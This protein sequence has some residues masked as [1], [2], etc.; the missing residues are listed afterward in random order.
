MN[1]RISLS[2]HLKD[3]KWRYITG[4]LLLMAT[5]GIQAVIPRIS[6]NIIDSIEQ[7]AIDGGGI[8]RTGG[9]IAIL[10]FSYVL[11]RFLSRYQIL[12]GTNLFDRD[13]RDKMFAYLT[14]LSMKYFN[15]HSTGD[16]MALSTNDLRTVRMAL[17]R[18][19]M[20]LVGALFSIIISIVIMVKTVS[21]LMTAIVFIPFPFLMFVMYRFGPVMRRRFL[22]VQESFS[23]MVRKAEENVSGIRV[24][25]AFVQERP[26]IRNFEELNEA[27]FNAN[28]RMI[29][30]TSLFHPLITVLGSVSA[31]LILWVGGTMA[32]DG[33]ISVGDFV[34]SMQYVGNITRPFAMM[35]MILELIQRARASYGRLLKLFY[36]KPDIVNPVEEKEFLD[37]A[38]DPDHP[39]K[40]KGLIE[41]KN[42]TFAY[43]EDLP[44]S[45]KDINLTIRPGETLGIIGR[46]GSGKSSL[47]QLVLRLYDTQRRGM[48]FIDGVDIQDIPLSML[49]RSVGYVPQQNFLFSDSIAA[50]INFSPESRTREEI[51]QAAHIACIDDAIDEL[52]DGYDAELG[53]RGVNLSGGQK[54][55]I[56]IARAISKDPTILVLDDCLS[57]VDTQTE[58]WILSQLRPYSADRT[59]LIIGHRVSTMQY[60]DRVAVLDEGRLVELGT[61]EELLNLGGIYSE[62]YHRQQL[63]A[64]VEREG[65]AN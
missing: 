29:R 28:F 4:S 43:D 48:L 25:K 14:T 21:P 56:S 38:Y 62:I 12:N 13:S 27:N 40:L 37:D 6:G 7:S 36:E 23:D 2:R 19:I 31:L 61:H 17:M 50:N 9:I 52:P 20:V 15:R 34:A 63:E 8:L 26:E 47:A 3:N 5:S 39:A 53:E 51:E 59:T 58:E 60:A 32:L 41:M 65:G 24:I 57:A 46:I 16:I 49:R 33:R 45:L 54:Q 55:R 64:K 18:G 11:L 1:E 44:D 30:T 10:A 22:I 35:G 42:L